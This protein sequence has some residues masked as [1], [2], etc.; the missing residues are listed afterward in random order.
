MKFQCKVSVIPL[1]LFLVVG[2]T[3][4]PTAPTVAAVAAVPAAQATTTPVVP[5]SPD[6]AAIRKTARGLGLTPRSSQN[7]TELYCR[8]APEIGTR[9]PTTICYTNSQVLELEKRKQ[10]NQDD[11]DA[12]QKASLTEPNKG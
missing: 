7:G 6:T 12:I 8:S 2:C 11:I 4:A 1:L 5:V 3:S 10:S 9:L